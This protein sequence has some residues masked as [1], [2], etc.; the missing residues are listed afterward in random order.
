MGYRGKIE[1]QNRARDLRAEGLTYNEI[2]AELGVSKSSVSLWCRDVE[3]DEEVWASRVRENKRFGARKRTNTLTL[4]RQAEIDR[5]LAEG[6]ERIGRLSARDF[7]IAG[8][9]LY[10]GEG[11]KTGNAVVFANSD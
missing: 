3:V 9:A 1:E 10:A 4:R 6:R 2:C 8:V 5:L 7:L 11:A